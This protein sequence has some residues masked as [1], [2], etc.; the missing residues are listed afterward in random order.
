MNM[1]Q[2]W[3]SEGL[4]VRILESED[5]SLVNQMVVIRSI[6]VRIKLMYLIWFEVHQ[7]F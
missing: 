3:Y 4:V 2:E 6:K 1:Q 7:K 5:R